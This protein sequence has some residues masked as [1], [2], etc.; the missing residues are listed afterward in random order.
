[1]HRNRCIISLEPGK[2][3]FR[4]TKLNE[5]RKVIMASYLRRFFAVFVGIFM[6]ISSFLSGQIH[7]LNHDL[8]VELNS[9]P[10]TGCS[11]EVVID[12]EDAVKLAD[13][14][15]RNP[16]N[17]EGISGKPGTDIFYFDAVADGKATVTFTYGQQW[18]EDGV[19]RTIV[20]E[21]ESKDSAIMV[22]NI[23]DSE[24]PS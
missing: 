10:S 5:E 6:A 15:Y 21:C 7:F 8:T 2:P 16:I 4:K 23:T 12:N 22:L 1:M 20:Y 9:N 19:V 13:R 17:I 18:K 14:K 3:V 11:W 24:Y